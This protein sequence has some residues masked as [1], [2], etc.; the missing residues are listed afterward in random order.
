MTQIDTP[1]NIP[2]QD[3]AKLKAWMSGKSPDKAI[4]AMMISAG[5]KKPGKVIKRVAKATSTV[6]AEPKVVTWTKTEQF[7]F[8]CALTTGPG[9][10]VIDDA[11]YPGLGETNF[12]H[13]DLYLRCQNGHTEINVVTVSAVAA[14]ALENKP[15]DGDDL[16]WVK[17]VLSA[18]R[19]F[20][21]GLDDAKITPDHACSF[22]IPL[23]D[24][25]LEAVNVPTMRTEN[26]KK[27]SGQILLVRNVIRSD[28][29]S[30]T[31]FKKVD[32]LALAMTKAGHPGKEA[33][34]QLVAKNA[35]SLG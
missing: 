11:D 35:T 10:A 32:G 19:I 31:D 28:E 26:G 7:V 13:T 30:D 21:T 33:F 15:A 27:K 6:F 34:G 5:A 14:H 17:K 22:L 18:A 25:Y 9:N 16:A 8:A 24:T 3:H 20:A 12:Y 29:L 4:A 1:Q 2:F 23:E